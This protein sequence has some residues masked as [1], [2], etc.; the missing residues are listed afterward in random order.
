MGSN[1]K[2]C[3]FLFLKKN[4]IKDAS[5]SNNST[6]TDEQEKGDPRI[7]KKK[8]KDFYKI[9]VS[10]KQKRR[11]KIWSVFIRMASKYRQQ[12]VLKLHE[13]IWKA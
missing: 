9:H 3:W 12:N 7:H 10:I 8:R 13:K 4:S 5:V 11:I 6:I 1:K 2:K